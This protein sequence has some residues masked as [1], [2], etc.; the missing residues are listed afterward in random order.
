MVKKAIVFVLIAFIFAPFLSAKPT[1]AFDCLQ[2]TSSSSQSDKDY[3][4]K[5]LNEIEAQLR[6][7]LEKQK[8]QQKQTG[9]LKGDVAYLQSQIDALRAKIK[10]RALI[11][12]QLKVDIAE[13]NT[14][15]KSLSQK[16]EREHESLAQ[17]LRNTNEFDNETIIHLVLS[18]ESLSNFYSDL[19]SYSSIKRAVKESVD[20]I[21]GIK[22]DTEEAKVDL[23]KK[24]DAE[25]DAKAELESAQKKVAV[26]EAEKK[27]LLAIS[28]DTEVAYQQLAAEKKARADKIR[29]AL[30]PLANTTSKIDFGTALAYAKEA[31]QK[32]GIDPAFLL[33]VLTQESNLGSNVGQCY[34]TNQATGAGAGK[35]TGTAF[36]NVMKPMGMPGRKGDVEDFLRITGKLG[37]VWNQTPVSCP[38]AGVGG[39]GGAMGPAQFIPTTWTI[40]ENRLKNTLGYDASPWAPKD[41]FFASAM[42]LTDLG[43]VGTSAAAQM[44]AACRYYGTGGASCS[45]SN[46]VMNHKAKI[47]AN[48]DLL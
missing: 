10:S 7:L 42:Y 25:T 36:A 15:I 16:I 1:A 35:N 26:S 32:T 21:R 8:A 2:L 46:G 12:S 39:Y 43:A 20:N 11:I 4:K 30:F 28:Q 37:L 24:H 6:E 5:E 33:A 22:T 38:I 17:L 27:K 3:C 40:F 34:L 13:K 14:E 9:T 23:E 41:A 19:E 44:K 18:D 47:Q 45:Y 29:A 31:Q 48:I